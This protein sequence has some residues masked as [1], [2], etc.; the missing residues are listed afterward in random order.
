MGSEKKLRR[1]VRA[2]AMAFALAL[3]PALAAAPAVAQSIVS[4]GQS[5]ANVSLVPGRSAPDGGRIAGVVVDLAPDWKTYWRH[6][7]AAGVPPAFDWSRSENLASAEVLWPRPDVFETFGLETL[8]YSKR[9]VFPVRLVPKDPAKPI[10]LRL[11]LAMGVCHD[12]CVLE[13]TALAETIAPDAPEKGGPMVADA[14]ATVP[15]PAASVGLT[16]AQCRIGGAGKT[17]RFEATLTFDRSLEAPRVVLEGPELA[18]F[19]DVR[20]DT[21]PGSGRLRVEAEVSLLDE[22]AW[23][24]RSDIR[25]TVLDRDFAADLKG[26]GSSHG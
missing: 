6:P 11:D 21:E 22:R 3:A 20:T 17:R 9:V 1:P 5:F 4:T 23:L 19:K 2:R 25:M 13:E 16:E 10:E 12:I 18:W 24:G 15:P 7:G 26:C 14:E 8:G